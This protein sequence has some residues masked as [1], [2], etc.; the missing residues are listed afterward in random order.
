MA[1]VIGVQQMQHSSWSSNSFSAGQARAFL[2]RL[3]AGVE[4]GAANPLL[5]LGAE[6]PVEEPLLGA[7][8]VIRCSAM[9]MPH[10]TTSSHAAPL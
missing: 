10:A 6:L 4:P 3:E 2:F 1:P 9:T 7:G 5:G 8:L